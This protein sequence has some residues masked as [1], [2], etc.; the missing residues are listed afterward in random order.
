MASCGGTRG[1]AQPWYMMNLP[2]RLRKA[3][4]SALLAL[5][6]D[7]S[8]ESIVAMLPS[9]SKSGYVNAR[10]NTHLK[11]E[12]KGVSALPLLPDQPNCVSAS[13]PRAVP[14]KISAPVRGSCG[15]AYIFRAASTCSGA[16]HLPSE[17]PGAHC[18]ADGSHVQV[19]GS[20]RKG[21]V[22]RPP[23]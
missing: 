14:G 5:T 20:V 9:K 8:I 7:A 17:V 12:P 22:G 13:A 16:R 21:S 4:R 1:S 6:F 19:R 2:P 3:D 10:P 11:M 15:P 18:T 23:L